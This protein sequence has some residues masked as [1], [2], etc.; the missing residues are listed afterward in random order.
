MRGQIE[1]AGACGVV[2]DVQL[3]A[4]EGELIVPAEGAQLYLSVV[5]PTYNEKDNSNRS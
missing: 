2:M 1:G 3:P 5:V 4:K